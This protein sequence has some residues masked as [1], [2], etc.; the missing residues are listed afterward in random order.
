[1]LLALILLIALPL[2]EL[3]VLILVGSSIGPFS[4]I[5]LSLGTAALGTLLV[6]HQGFGVLMRVRELS[7]RGVTPAIEMMD[8][9]LLLIAGLFLLLPGFLTD[10]VGFLLLVPPLRQW[11]VAR[12]VR[13]LVVPPAA[14]APPSAPRAPRMIEGEFRR[15]DD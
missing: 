2:I 1:M 10:A 3:Y 13:T 11:L 9:A 5:V 8:G 14:S 6:R 12:Y 15:E 7:D 4:T